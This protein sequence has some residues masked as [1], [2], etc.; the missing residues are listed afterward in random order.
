ME[1][2]EIRSEL[3]KSI[4][5][6]FALR[7]GNEY[8]DTLYD[9]GFGKFYRVI[10]T[11]LFHFQNTLPMIAKRAP[12]RAFSPDGVCDLYVAFFIDIGTAFARYE[13]WFSLSINEVCKDGYGRVR[14]LYTKC[15][16]YFDWED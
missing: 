9:W 8:S 1:F 10:R 11:A 12:L 13:S 6:L 15:K 4:G 16:S 7:I 3:I 5:G 2:R 14:I